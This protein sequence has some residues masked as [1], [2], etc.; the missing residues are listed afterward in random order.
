MLT[1]K[2]CRRSILPIPHEASSF[3]LP[4]KLPK[5]LLP[6]LAVAGGLGSS[7]YAASVYTDGVV[8]S[9]GGPLPSGY[10]II[11]SVNPGGTG[12][13]GELGFNIDNSLLLT[14]VTGTVGIGHSWF[15]VVQGQVIGSL[16]V[17]S[18][19]PLGSVTGTGSSFGGQIQLQSGQSFLIGFWLDS[20]GLDTP[21][22]SKGDGLPGIDDRYGW[23]RLS[24]TQAGGLV[25][26]ESATLASDSAFTSILAGTTTAI[27]E[28]S[29]L[30]IAAVAGG[31][32]LRRRR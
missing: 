18:G 6:F 27:P 28:S 30:M 32:A 23:A 2:S 20:G 11:A 24:Y 22:A 1:G 13:L 29:T 7:A 10:T 19:S 4:M 12:D 21:L 25:L 16:L 17:S 14:S 15:S 5:A 31:F 8:A 26:L 9:P 3:D